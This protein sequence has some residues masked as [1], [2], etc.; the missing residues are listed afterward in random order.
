MHVPEQE[1]D[2]LLSDRH[3]RKTILEILRITARA[4]SSFSDII[5]QELRKKKNLS[6]KRR[7][8]ISNAAY[9]M[10][11]MTRL[12]DF[13]LEYGGT[14]T[15]GTMPAED[16]SLARFAVALLSLKG[17]TAEKIGAGDFPDWIHALV[18]RIGSVEKACATIEDSCEEL[19]TE[20]S[21]PSWFTKRVI[22]ERGQREAEELLHSMNTRAPLTLRANTLKVSAEN[23]IH[24]L[25]QEDI[26]GHRG[27]LSPWSVKLEGHRNIRALYAYRKGYMEAQ[28]EGSQLIALLAAPPENGKVLDLCAG[29]GG[30]TLALAA[31]MKN[32]G[33]VIATDIDPRRLSRLRPRLQRSG[34][35]NIRLLPWDTKLPKGWRGRADRVL[36]DAPCS[37]SGTLRRNPGMRWQLSEEEIERLNTIQ[38]DLLKNA[39]K[40]V[41]PGGWI[42]YA[43]CSIL[44]AENE[45]IVEKV[46]AE[47]P[48]L[49]IL[50]PS[51]IVGEELGA[52]ISR[53]AFMSLGPNSHDVDGFFTAVIRL[54]N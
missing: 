10:V 1:I 32:K 49:E 43:T 54:K 12:I 52:S 5:S 37:G 7:R 22:E 3:V 53:G 28:D 34:A 9:M 50:H 20:S 25:A 6:S 4:R 21:M 40:L 35:S 23:L 41:R 42:I 11:R 31:M 46:L 15:L 38:A 8:A 33:E 16:K 39:K 48:E 2:L 51:D 14:E 18:H 27:L 19:A 36:I 29:A 47:D 13:L 26:V 24:R 17:V 45:E 30:K 44:R